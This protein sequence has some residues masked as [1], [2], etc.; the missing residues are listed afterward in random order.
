MNV[1]TL[2]TLLQRL[3]DLME[4]AESKGAKDIRAL[5]NNLT[6]FENLPFTDFAAFLLKAEAF[7]RGDLASVFPKSK[8]KALPTPKAPKASD[9]PEIVSKTILELRT[10]HERALDESFNEEIVSSTL[11]KVEKLRV[12]QL[13]QITSGCGF[14]QSF[15]SKKA[16]IDALR[17]WIL[18]RKGTHERSGA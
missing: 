2:H 4:A 17:K 16:S 14:H 13:G 9:D 15:K 8:G 6:P 3:A 11:A 18:S 5:A 12:D 7:S 1:S 10:L